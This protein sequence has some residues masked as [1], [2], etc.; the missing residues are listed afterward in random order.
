[1]GDQ[2]LQLIEPLVLPTQLDSE[3][4]ES[5][6]DDENESDTN[7][8]CDEDSTDYDEDVEENETMLQRE[9]NEIGLTKAECLVSA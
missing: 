5:E 3:E 7:H 6:S 1:M 8:H 2:S 9:K 4:S